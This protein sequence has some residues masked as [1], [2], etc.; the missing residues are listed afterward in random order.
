MLTVGMVGQNSQDIAQAFLHMHGSTAGCRCITITDVRQNSPKPDVLVVSEAAPVLAE[1]IPKM[2]AE[3]YLV[4][5]ADDKAIFPY[6]S[7][8]CARTITYGFNNRA[9]ITASSISEE[10]LQA[11]IQRAFTSIDGYQRDP[12]EFTAP[13]LIIPT[14]S[15]T[16]QAAQKII[17][18][19]AA[20]AAAAVWAICG[21][22]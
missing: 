1:L 16:Q 14:H 11:C 15:H 3:N 8:N 4:I 12:Q 5:N 6:L 13:G 17:S 19:E 7:H 10:G 22:L 2:S 21:K 18:P 9:C 20:L